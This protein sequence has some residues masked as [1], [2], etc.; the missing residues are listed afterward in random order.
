MYTCHALAVAPP[1]SGGYFLEFCSLESIV[2]GRS[3]IPNST[4]P[5][6]YVCQVHPLGDYFMVLSY[7]LTMHDSLSSRWG[8]VIVSMTQ[9]L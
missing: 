9:F 8:P 6:Q 7:E 5:C 3:E 1:R 4:D 2:L